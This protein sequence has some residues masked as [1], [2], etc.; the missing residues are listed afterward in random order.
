MN[1]RQLTVYLCGGISTEPDQGEA[2]FSETQLTMESLGYNVINPK[3][4][5]K[6]NG[7]REWSYY[8]CLDVIFILENKPDIILVN[9]KNWHTSKG[10]KCEVFN[11]INILGIPVVELHE[12]KLKPCLHPLIGKLCVEH[13]IPVLHRLT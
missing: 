12:N 4:I 1:K 10:C 5:E 2:W 3:E 8:L 13:D 6:G 9:H 7:L 11:C